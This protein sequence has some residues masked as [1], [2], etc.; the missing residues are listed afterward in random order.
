M[1]DP[2][3]NRVKD[4]SLRRK[5]AKPA[6]AGEGHHENAIRSFIPLQQER[7]SERGRPSRKE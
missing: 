2:L 7:A 4:R 1:S 3:V 5:K 6:T